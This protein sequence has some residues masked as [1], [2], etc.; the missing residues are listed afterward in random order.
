MIPS[1]ISPQ[2][3]IMYKIGG[4]KGMDAKEKVANQPTTN[5][6]DKNGPTSIGI[7][8]HVHESQRRPNQSQYI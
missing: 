8:R 2:L 4:G 6:A 7:G 1:A 5:R 3:I